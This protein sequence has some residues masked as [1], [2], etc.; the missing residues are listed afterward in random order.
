MFDRRDHRGLPERFAM[1]STGAR[2]MPIER[3]A[4]HPLDLLYDR[5]RTMAD[6]VLAGQ[7]DFIDGVDACYSAALWAGLVDRYG[8]D[9]VQRILALPFIATPKGYRT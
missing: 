3:D 4:R 2:A 5:T 7:V 6:R 9:A 1:I 8:D